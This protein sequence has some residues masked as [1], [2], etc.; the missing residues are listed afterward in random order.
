MKGINK[1]INNLVK[2]I[3]PNCVATFST[4]M[5]YNIVLVQKFYKTSSSKIIPSTILQVC[6]AY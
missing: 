6:T 2:T 4:K 5:K 3:D 1:Y